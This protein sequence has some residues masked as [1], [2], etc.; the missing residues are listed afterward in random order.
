MASDV[1]PH[2]SRQ[3]RNEAKLR[4]ANLRK[5]AEDL[6]LDG[7]SYRQIGEVVPVSTST[8]SLWLRDV[9]LTE[10]HRQLLADRQLEGRVRAVETIKARALARRRRVVAEAYAQISPIK[11]NELFLA[12]VVAYWAEGTKAKPWNLSSS[13]QFMNSD[14]RMIKLFLAWLALLGIHND[15]LVFRLQIHE[16]AELQIALR[17]W[18]HVVGVETS[19]LRVTLK[20]HNPVTR[21]KN[22][23]DDYRGCLIVY[24]TRSTELG[25]RI[26]GWFEG[27]M[28]RLPEGVSMPGAGVA[29]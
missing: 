12:G 20:R 28:D 21:R 23:G 2:S 9:P 1:V 26:A 4:R 19:E 16:S 3:P 29:E 22:I 17:F 25:R 27:I 10:E 13:V 24:V 11:D 7:Q 18:S 15:R 6:R 5:I 14:F 8:L